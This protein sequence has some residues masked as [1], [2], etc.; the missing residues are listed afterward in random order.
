MKGGDELCSYVPAV[1]NTTGKANARGLSNA[2]Q[3]SNPDAR[4]T[5]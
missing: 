3:T 2:A 4:Q 1:G 5:A